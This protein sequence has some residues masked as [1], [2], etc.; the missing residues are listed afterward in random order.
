MP[1]VPLRHPLIAFD[2]D[3]TLV[4]SADGR[5]V[6]QY[7]NDHF[8]PDETAEAQRFKAYLEG[9]ITYPEWVDLDIGQWLRVGARRQVIAEV[10]TQ[11]LYLLPGAREAT[12]ALRARGHT[13]AVI[14]GTLDLVLEL[15]FPSHPFGEVFTNTIWFDEQGLIDGWKATPYDMEGKAEALAEIARRQGFSLEQ[16]AYVGDNMNDIQVMGAAGVAVA[17]EPKAPE[18]AAAADHVIRGDLRELLSLL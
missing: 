4:G 3:G 16:T 9:Q 6:W 17:F 18:V 1:A 5:V 12:T 13:L 14:S 7:L 11:N 10:I 2:V 15:L 8:A